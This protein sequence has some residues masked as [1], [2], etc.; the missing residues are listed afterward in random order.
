MDS[1]FKKIFLEKK[2]NNNIKQILLQSKFF[3]PNFLDIL[4]LLKISE[5]FSFQAIK[6]EP[7]NLMFEAVSLG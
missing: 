6:Y 5:S 4:N 1:T 3:F 2:Q 7:I